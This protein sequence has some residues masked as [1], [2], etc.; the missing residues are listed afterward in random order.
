[1]NRWLAAWFPALLAVFLLLGA[2]SKGPDS[3][4]SIG[5][6]KDPPE[7]FRQATSAMTVHLPRDIGAH[8]AYRLEWWYLTANL[9]SADGEPFGVQWTLFRNGVRPGPFSE[10]VPGWQRNELWLAHAAVSRPGAHYFADRAARGGTG[11][12]GVTAQPFHA[13]IDHWQLSSVDDDTW[14]LSVEHDNFRYSLQIQPQAPAVL[15]GALGFSAKSD[16]GG[17][18]M[19]FSYPLRVTGGHIEIGEKRFRVSGQGWFDREWSSQYLKPDQEGWD[20][21][22][23]HLSDGRH[24]MLFRVRG[25]NDFYSATLVSST[26]KSQTLGAGDFSLEPIAYRSSRFGRVPTNWQ[27]Q[28]PESGIDIQ[29]ESW[30][31]D[32]WNPGNLRYWEGPVEV[33]GSHS[34]EGYLE[35]TG[36]GN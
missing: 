4:S 14:E 13:W 7:G 12:A 20:W 15:H 21:M 5:A 11:Q 8:P 23:L 36:Y 16:S 24:L 32:Y 17:G 27:L 2:C 9:K 34:G 18:S 25:A 35:M 1:M 30:P 3:N 33:S 19:Y 29:V 26:G 22:A 31:G 28:V 6:L 10:M